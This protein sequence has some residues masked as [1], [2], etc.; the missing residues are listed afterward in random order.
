MRIGIAGDHVR[1]MVKEQVLQDRRV[2]NGA[3]GK[4]VD[5]P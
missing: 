4:H 1:C 5:S 3:R 2:S